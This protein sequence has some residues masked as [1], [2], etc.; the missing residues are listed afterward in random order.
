MDGQHHGNG[1]SEGSGRLNGC[2]DQ[3]RERNEKRE[4]MFGGPADRGFSIC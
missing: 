3:R 2:V 1:C 4:A